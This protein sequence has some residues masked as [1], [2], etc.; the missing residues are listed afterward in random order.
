MI[1]IVILVFLFI[2]YIVFK[3]LKK[4]AQKTIDTGKDAYESIRNSQSFEEAYRNFSSNKFARARLGIP[5]EVIA[6]MAKVSLSDGKVSELEIEYMS[7]TIKAIANA[8]LAAGMSEAVVIEIKKQL[9]KLA[10]QAKKDA[11]PVSYYCAELSQSSKDVRIQAM[12]QILAFASLDG[13]SRKTTA[14][15]YEIGA[16]LRFS[17]AEVNTLINDLMGNRQTGSSFQQNPYEVLGCNEADEFSIIKQAYRR[18]VKKHHPDYLHSKGVDD[19]EIRKATEKMQVIN[20]AYEEI[21]KRR[22]I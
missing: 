2:I 22:N 9:F 17:T 3:I 16:C 13:L 20:A 4:G 18:L 10:N 8:M 6:L 7:D 21:K 14:L 12:R 1:R 19:S 11:N 5:E 15:L